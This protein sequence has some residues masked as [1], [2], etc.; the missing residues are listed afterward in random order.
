MPPLNREDVLAFA[1]REIQQFHASRLAALER[2]DLHGCGYFVFCLFER[3]Q[4][5]G[6]STAQ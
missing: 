2:I 1:N 5:R 3:S 4:V 6:G